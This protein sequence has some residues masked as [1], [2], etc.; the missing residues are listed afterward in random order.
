MSIYG[1]L[2]GMK[3]L[4]LLLLLPPAFVL[5]C[6]ALL[7][8]NIPDLDD[9]DAI[10]KHLA[11][12]LSD[13][14]V[15]MFAPHNEHRIALT[16]LTADAIL[17]VNG[18][19]SFRW[20]ILCGNLLLIAYGFL[21]LKIFRAGRRHLAPIGI[22]ILW[23]MLS[24]AH[25]E[26]M[27][28][29]MTSIQ[30]VAVMLF[31]LLSLVLGMGA[32][33][34]RLAATVSCATIATFSS[35]GGVFIWPCLLMCEWFGERRRGNLVTILVAAIAMVLLFAFVLPS[36]TTP[37]HVVQDAPKPGETILASTTIMNFSVQLTPMFI[38][39]HIGYAASLF[40]SLMG[41]A[42]TFPWACL[43][44][45]ILVV[46]LMTPI[47][48]DFRR[49]AGDPVFCFL[50]FL[51]ANAIPCAVF[52]AVE[53]MPSVPSRYCIV[54]VS[55]LAAT[56]YLTKIEMP[57]RRIAVCL[58]C[59]AVFC[60]AWWFGKMAERADNLRRNFLM[61]PED[62]TGLAYP[63]DRLNSANQILSECVRRGI[64]MPPKAKPGEKAPSHPLPVSW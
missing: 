14:L 38:V 44:L 63:A 47:A 48:A 12:P 25:R 30:N 45:G 34:F 15:D 58:I 27:L 28:W 33:P 21:W 53:F 64:Y 46:A 43:A 18:I 29:A 40:I 41:G 23:L 56:L 2:H 57:A 13:R 61:W 3:K 39:R 50:V 36:A 31:A 51:I 9:F 5:L 54:S 59:F 52:R 26:N 49:H 42:A 6:W 55:I 7:S 8:V 60:N 37:P 35:G 4:T 19:F 62:V 22:G 32:G 10:L 17:A 16:K 20:M 11:A 24:L 1:I